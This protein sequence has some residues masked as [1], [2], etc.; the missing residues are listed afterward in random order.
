MSA[1]LA[2]NSVLPVLMSLVLE[3][4]AVHHHA[5]WEDSLLSLFRLCEDVDFLKFFA[6]GYCCL[7]LIVCMCS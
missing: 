5:Q 7:F 1:R 4:T 3:M 6:G 2:P